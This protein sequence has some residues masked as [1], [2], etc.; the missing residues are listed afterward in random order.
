MAS[1][2][3]TVQA[4]LVAALAMGF[5]VVSA[6]PARAA[7]DSL[8][9][10]GSQLGGWGLSSSSESIPGPT[11]TVSQGDSVTI[12]LH[13]TDGLTH[14]F[15]IDFNGD[16]APSAGEPTSSPFNVSTT[17]ST[18]T[19]GQAGTFHYYCYFHEN[20]M[21]GSFVVTGSAT[22][23]PSGTGGSSALPT[24]EIVGVVVVLVVAVGVAALVLRQR[25][26]QP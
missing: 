9:L 22:T 15:F 3:R 11:L 18:F 24:L 13:S 6:P 16:G 20:S 19:A 1:A 5:A 2:K 26:K 8:T 21:K 25:S 23:G 12:T 10:Y 14:E 4:F 17:V 7:S